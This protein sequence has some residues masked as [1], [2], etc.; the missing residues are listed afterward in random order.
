MELLI[1]TVCLKSE[2]ESYIFKFQYG[3]TNI[4]AVEGKSLKSQKFKFQYGATNIIFFFNS[5]ITIFWFKFQYG[6]TNI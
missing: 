6:A 1:S 2:N 4:Q 5:F 3:A